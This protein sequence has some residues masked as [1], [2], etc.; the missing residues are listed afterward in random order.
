M[1]VQSETEAFSDHLHSVKYRGRGESFEQ[2]MERI[3]QVLCEDNDHRKRLMDILMDRRFLPAGRVQSGAG[4]EKEVT[5]FN[6][7][8]AGTI[9]DHLVGKGSIMDRATEAARTMKMG[10]GIGFDFSS[11]RPKGALI[12]KLDSM[13][14]GPISFMGI[15]NAIGLA[16]SSAG[17]RRGAMMA[18]LRVDHPDIEAFIEAKQNE[19]ALTGFN[20]SVNITDDFVKA[21]EADTDFDLLWNYEPQESVNARDLWNRI[22]R[23]TYDY[24]E[25]GVLFMDQANR[26]NNLYYCE[27]MS[28]TNPCV[29]GD[30]EVLTS[31]G[32]RTVLSLVGKPFTAIVNG[33]PHRSEGFFQTGVKPTYR[34]ETVEGHHCRLTEDHKVLTDSGFVPAKDLNDSHRI[35]MNGESSWGGEGTYD[36]GYLLGLLMGDGWFGGDG[37]ATLGVWGSTNDGYKGIVER[38]TAAFNALGYSRPA[39]DIW[40]PVMREGKVSEW[41]A[42]STFLTRLAERFGVRRGNK[43]ITE[44]IR[45]ASSDF[46]RG[47]ISGMFD[48]DGTVVGSR[49][50]KGQ[51]N[52]GAALRIGQAN[53]DTLEFIQATLANLGINS[54]LY[55]N[56]K[57]AGHHD[58]P[59]GKGG[60]KPYFTKAMHELSVAGI[61]A[62]KF[63]EMIETHDSRKKEKLGEALDRYSRGPYKDKGL[64][65]KSLIRDGIEPVYDCTVPEVS[66]FVCNGIIVHNCSEQILPPHG[67]CL[68]GSF[69]LTRYLTETDNGRWLNLQRLENDIPVV[70]KAM[71]RVTDISLYPLDE[72]QKE[73]ISKRRMG[74]G[75]TGVANALEHLGHKYASP[76][77]L[78]ILR[79][80]M[81]V[82]RDCAYAASTEIAR[83]K[84]PF[85]MFDRDL[86]LR[87]NFVR[88]LPIHIRRGIAK[89][90][91]RNS[92]LTSIAPTGT[93]SLCAGNVSS[94]IEPVFA[95]RMKRKVFFPEGQREVE[96]V[97]YG[98]RKLGVEGKTTS[99]CTVNDHLNVLKTVV[100]YVD[101][102]VSK[103]VN[104]PS[105]MPFDDFKEVYRKAHAFGAKGLS[106]FRIGGERAGIMEDASESESEGDG[107]S[108][109][110]DEHGHLS[111]E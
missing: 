23:S 82:L 20:V 11:L 41:R 73:A 34:L 2:A 25:P 56:R 102:A 45:E 49:S 87:G 28:A 17:H 38:A 55:K 52:D 86:Y 61:N 104:I 80:T 88:D 93:I 19:H 53:L 22:M 78:T 21:L 9:E 62:V 12:E 30:C 37:K 5:C 57:A 43:I 63:A 77:F 111:C 69:N 108:C 36:E 65:L 110:L 33:E 105:D 18:V 10:G 1:N 109:E 99:D 89:H 97:D 15:F 35:V 83:E 44:K 84:E 59:D 54:A 96:I 66:R 13:S 46:H 81:A 3:A 50:D 64:R 90:G 72:Q 103:T 29:T 79:K 100:P 74:L 26:M 76:K 16:I 6:C 91:I 51:S 60:T 39:D 48:A 71:D 68:L 95:H 27:T 101:S 107:V 7:Y 24:A 75:V 70:V 92:H 94:G 32:P 4:S 8:V 85:P 31:E 58:F 98:V 67:A 42:S 106:T 47:F 40:R 14:S